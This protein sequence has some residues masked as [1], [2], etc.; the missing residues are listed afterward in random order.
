MERSTIFHGKFH[1]FYGDFPVRYV[2]LPE[3]NEHNMIWQFVRNMNEHDINI[4]HII[5]I[6][7][8]INIINMECPWSALTSSC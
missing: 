5:N 6:S 8:I 3:G 1:Y 4:I 2:K 7:S